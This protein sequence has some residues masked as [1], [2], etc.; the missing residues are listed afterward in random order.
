[1]SLILLS[2]ALL[3]GF[4][5]L[6]V[7]VP[8][9]TM[10][11][12]ALGVGV[13]ELS[14][15]LLVITLAIAGLA[16]RG[17][18]VADHWALALTLFAAVLFILPIL[19]FARIA[20]DAPLSIRQLVRGVPVADARVTRAIQFAAPEDVPLTLDVYQPPS[21]GRFPSIVQIY[22]GAWQRGTPGNDEGFA[23][24]LASRGFVVFAIDYRHAPVWQWPAQRDDV[25]AALA[26]I[27]THASGYDA[28][29]ARLALVGRS[30]GAQLAL[31]EAFQNPD[32]RA[33]VSFYGPVNLT[34]G[35]HEPPTPDPIDTKSVLEAYLGGTPAQVPERYRDASPITQVSARTPPTLLLYGSR[36]HIVEA[37]FGRQ[38][39]ERLQAAG[40]SSQL[41]EIP[42]AEHAFDA[43][44]G[45]LSGQLSWFH[46]ERFLAQS[47]K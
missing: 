37:H 3:M 12:L 1:M 19:Q 25:R 17:S 14:P 46:T 10:T 27:R 23:R 2:A 31:A 21:S 18:G 36:D 47:L 5:A 42:W 24:R 35:W 4:L 30:A 44:S 41:I 16:W 32:V 28:D 26:W 7:V 34:Q 43:L 15:V 9:P 20:T 33:V 38:L 39:H 29:P 13:P 40:A 6:W 8:A 45:G 22:G 11:L